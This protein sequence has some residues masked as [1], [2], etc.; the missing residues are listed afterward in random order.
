VLDSFIAD[1]ITSIAEGIGEGANIKEILNSILGGFGGFLK[2][3]GKL[4]IKYGVAM[5]AFRKALINPLAAIVAGVALVAVGSLIAK[6]SK[7]AEKT[8]RGFAEGGRNISAG[9]AV[10]GERGREVID[11]PGGS[12]IIPNHSLGG[13]SGL[14]GGGSEIHIHFDGA[15]VG[16]RQRLGQELTNILKRYNF[17]I[18]R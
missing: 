10:V 12:N 9:L 5:A 17:N 13:L 1:S 3:M 11:V 7:N 18:N 16:D 15:F 14:R 4:L 8:I 2:D 6:K